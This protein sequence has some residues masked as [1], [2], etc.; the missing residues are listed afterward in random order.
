MISHG[1]P[2]IPAWVI[3]TLRTSGIDIDFQQCDTPEDIVL[4]AGGA[5]VLWTFATNPSFTADA[6]RQIILEALPGLR[7]CRVIIRSGSGTDN[8]PVPEASAKGILVANTPGAT[9]EPVAEYAIA[10]MLTVMRQV[11]FD[12]RRVRHGD[13]SQPSA[14]S[15]VSLM[16]KTVGL[17]G[18]GQIARLV[19]RRL[20]G[21]DVQLLA[22]DPAIDHGQLKRLGARAVTL[23]ELLEQSDVV[24]LHCPLL[25]STRGLIGHAQFERMKRSAI[26][27]NTARGG[28]VDEPALI[29]AL[30]TRRIAG[31]GLDVLEREPPPSDHP[32]LHMD[33]VVVT[34]HIA[35]FSEQVLHDMW[36]LSVETIMDLAQGRRPRSCVNAQP[37]A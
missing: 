20:S 27:I 14:P 13:W 12:A 7:R 4:L 26:L 37:P 21:F 1:E 10:L 18:F 15:A 11:V 2:K 8:V 29:Q 5:D 16:N 19:A 28:V 25:A 32:L 36:R 17:V 35:A 23:E 6:W 24:S 34:P 30:K 3:Q 31:A 9:A 22:T 33:H